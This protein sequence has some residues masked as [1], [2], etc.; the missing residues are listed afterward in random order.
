MIGLNME[1]RV[2]HQ[3]FG[4]GLEYLGLHSCSDYG[5][6][7]ASNE[8]VCLI[9]DRLRNLL[10]LLYKFLGAHGPREIL[11]IGPSLPAS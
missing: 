9:S 6:I 1:I 5:P 2:S 8:T 4:G 11:L 7:R 3:V 10:Y